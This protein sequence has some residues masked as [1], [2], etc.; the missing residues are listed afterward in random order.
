MRK[1]ILLIVLTAAFI[2]LSSS[3]QAHCQIP[4]G[5]FNDHLRVKLMSEHVTTIEKSMKFIDKLSKD[6]ASN[7]NQIVRWVNNKNDHADELT[8]IVTYYFL[9][10]RIKIIDS[11]DKAAFADY[12][13]KLSLLHQ[14]MVYSMKAKQTTDLQNTDKLRTLIADFDK[15]YFNERD[16]KHL[17]SHE[18]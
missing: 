5:I 10:Q 17:E 1:S 11:S 2:S 7:M 13:Q 15:A 6:P 14:I 12:Q 18:K 3:L 4:C 9:A 8:E 16:K